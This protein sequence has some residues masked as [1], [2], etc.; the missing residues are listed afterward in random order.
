[1]LVAARS[2]KVSTD[3]LAAGYR[4]SLKVMACKLSIHTDPTDEKKAVSDRKK[5]KENVNAVEN[6]EYH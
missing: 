1:M 5:K 6:Y 3:N 2:H 4:Q